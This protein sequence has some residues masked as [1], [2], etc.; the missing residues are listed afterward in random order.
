M[1]DDSET[2]SRLETYVFTD[3]SSPFFEKARAKLVAHEDR[4]EF[5]V[6]NIEE[7]PDLQEFKGVKYDI[8]VADNV[9][10]ATQAI[11]VS[12][13]NLRKLLK[14]GGKLFLKEMT[15]PLK[16]ITGFFSG[17]LPG[18]WRATEEYRIA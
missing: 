15:T 5:K 1:I 6:L 18:W 17:L 16:I 14:P 10:H 7:D 3:I 9:I 11:S 8:I 4:L 2:G 13:L 12:L